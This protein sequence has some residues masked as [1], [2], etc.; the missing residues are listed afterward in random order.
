MDAGAEYGPYTWMPATL[1]GPSGHVHGAEPLPGPYRWL[2]VITWLLGARNVSVHRTAP[3]GWCGRGRLSLPVRR[4]LPVHGRACPTAGAD[5]PGPHAEFRASHTVVAPVG[6]LD[7][8]PT[9][10]PSGTCG[11][12][13]AR[14][15]AG[16][17]AA[18]SPS[19]A[20]PTTVA[21]TS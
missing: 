2:R 11:T 16:G 12:R 20:S 5:G 10:S 13:A 15:T 9:R 3:G 7:Q 8:H 18:G 4:G 1:T 21:P 6:T 19:A 17:S 14:P